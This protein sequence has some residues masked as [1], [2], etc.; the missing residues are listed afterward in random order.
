MDKIEENR[1]RLDNAQGY[2]E[3]WEIV[4]DNAK[5]VLKQQRR[6]MMLFLDDM[7]LRLG[8][9]HPLG[10]NNIVLNRVLVQI[11]EATTKSRKLLNAFVYTLLLHEYL[12]ALGYIAE[13]EVRPLVYRVSKACFGEEHVATRLA[14]SGPW[15]LLR[16]VPLGALKAPRRVMEIVKD[17]EKTNQKYIV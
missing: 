9:Y 17:F 11:V 8:A 1:K 10:T 16:G 12:H 5:A 7:P 14:K 2:S 3:V 15:S 13:V 4:K 6:G